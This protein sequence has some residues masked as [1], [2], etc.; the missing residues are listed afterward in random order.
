MKVVE[1]KEGEWVMRQTDRMRI[2]IGIRAKCGTSN[3]EGNWKGD[4]QGRPDR[5]KGWWRGG[6]G[7]GQAEKWW[8]ESCGYRTKWLKLRGRE[9]GREGLG[10]TDVQTNLGGKGQGQARQTKNELGP[11]M[12]GRGDE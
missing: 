9:N 10:Q 3:N 12:E 7:D 8:L 11:M 4:G 2:L 6:G 1:G 5:S